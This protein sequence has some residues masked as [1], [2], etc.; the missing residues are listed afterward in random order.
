M[1]RTV[2]SDIQDELAATSSRPVYLVE[3]GFASTTIRL[4]SLGRDITWDSHSWLGNSWLMPIK[5]INETAEIRAVGVEIELV[6]VSSSLLALALADADQ[7][8]DALIYFAFLDS[9]G[10]VIADPILLFKGKV[11]TVDISDS[12]EQPSVVIRCES[13]LARLDRPTNFKYTEANQQALFSGDR[14]FQYLP[15]LE[16]WSGYWGKAERPSWL[17]RRRAKR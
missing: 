11:D 9:S 1:T 13:R 3:I 6:G 12:V 5:A 2:T 8:K 7:T 15:G 14:G 10:A 16:E 17:K 4:S